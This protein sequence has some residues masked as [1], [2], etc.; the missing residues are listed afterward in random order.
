MSERITMI[1]NY[2]LDISFLNDSEDVRRAFEIARR[3]HAGETRKIRGEPFLVHPLGVVAITNAYDSTDRAQVRGLLHDIVDSSTARERV[4]LHEVGKAFDIDLM[5]E[6]GSLSKSQK[7][8]DPAAQRKDYLLTTEEEE[9]PSVQITRA[10]DKIHNMEMAIE[11]LLWVEHPEQFWQNFKGGRSVYMQWPADVLKSI[12]NSGALEGHDIIDHYRQT[13]HKFYE[14]V[15]KLERMQPDDH[16]TL[17][18]TA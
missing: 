6:I 16:S 8:T 2:P 3:A 15:E 10:G 14:T 18:H 5:F 7:L 12:E 1:D 9:N 11:E 17:G 13:L 4:S